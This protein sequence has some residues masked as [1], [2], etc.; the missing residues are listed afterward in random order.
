MAYHVNASTGA[1]TPVAGNPVATGFGEID[2]VA[3][4]ASGTLAFVAERGYKNGISVY[5]INDA[6]G[7]LTKIPGSPFG[8]ADQTTFI[9]V[10]Q[11]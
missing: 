2:H 4:N 9:T 10:V 11:P 7:A 3:I 5:R 6:T 8:A 1:L